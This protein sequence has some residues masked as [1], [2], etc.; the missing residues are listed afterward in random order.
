MHKSH[1]RF[2]YAFPEESGMY[3]G[4]HALIET[5]YAY[6]TATPGLIVHKHLTRRGQWCIAH[7]GTGLKIKSFPTRRLA[8]WIAGVLG[9]ICEWTAETH[10]DIQAIGAQALDRTDMRTWLNQFH[11]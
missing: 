8:Y 3:R 2:V 11:S 5:V 7:I 4:K 6:T 9:G 1:K 10:A